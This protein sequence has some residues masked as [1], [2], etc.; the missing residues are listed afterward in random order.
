MKAYDC[1]KMLREIRDVA[2][3]SVDAYG[4]P[5]VRIIDVMYVDEQKLVFCTARGKDFYEELRSHPMI[6]ITGMTKQFEMIRVHGKA[7]QMK[8][9]KQWIDKIF[10]ENA[11]M[12][13]VYPGETRYIL[14]AFCIEKGEVEY[15]NLG[16]EPIDRC[17]VSLGNVEVR[18]KGYRIQE[19]CIGCGICATK[20]PQ[21]CITTGTPYVI[22]QA[23]CL[24]C[25]L[26]AE[27]CPVQAIHNIREDKV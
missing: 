7:E 9:Q 23:H 18:D 26:C 3:A 15:F 6:A 12:K 17:T 10:E 11:S 4:N 22:E 1:L 16:K 21:S 2:F 8:N 27:Y 25:G 13:A 19:S 24:H 20:C 14:E 5:R